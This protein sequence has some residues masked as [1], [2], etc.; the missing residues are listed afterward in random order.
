M[1][2]AIDRLRESKEEYEAGVAE[3]PGLK[4]LAWAQHVASYEELREIASLDFNKL[5]KMAADDPGTLAQWVVC[6]IG[7]SV[8][9]IFGLVDIRPTDLN[10]LR[11]FEAA[12]CFFREV[13]HRL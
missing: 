11:F 8:E 7:S 6:Q 12:G 10:A 4:G 1:T 3:R 13:E 2:S 5:R 9:D